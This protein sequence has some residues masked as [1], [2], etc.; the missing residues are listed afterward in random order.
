MCVYELDTVLKPDYCV[1]LVKGRENFQVKLCLQSTS[2]VLLRSMSMNL[3]N[4]L[5]RC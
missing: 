3:R 5:L 2:M 4:Y 1:I